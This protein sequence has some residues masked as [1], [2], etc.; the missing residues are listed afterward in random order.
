MAVSTQRESPFAGAALP[1][2]DQPFRIEQHGV[3]FIPLSERWARPRDVASMWAGASVQIEYF[4]YGAVLMTFG[5]TFAQALSLIIIGNLSYFLLGLCSLQGPQTGTTVF[6]INRASYGPNGSRVI[7][8]FNWLTQ[9]GFEVEG[10]ILIVGAALVLQTKAGFTAGTPAKVIFVLLAVAVQAVLPFLGHAT[11]VR[12]LRFLAIP[13]LVLFAVLLAFALPHATTTGVA[14]AADWQTYME[15]LAFTIVLSGLGWAECGND[16]SRYCRPDTSAKAIVGWVFLA[17]AVPEILIMT[18]GAAVGTF[19]PSVGKA[20]NAF[21]P[22]AHQHFIPAWFVVVFLVFSIV[23]LFAINS[24]DVYSS[25][26]T[27]QAMGVHVKRYV[28]VL[29]DCVIALGVTLYAIFASSFATYLKDFVDVVI[30]WIAPWAA[31][32]LTD[33]AMRRFRYV[34][35]ELQRTGRAS[36][37]YRENGVFWPAIVA[38][39][40][41]MYAAIS[42]LAATFPLPR[43]LNELTYATRDSYGYGADFSVFLGP[44]VAAVVYLALGWRGVR[45]QAAAQ[46]AA[47]AESAA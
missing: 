31:I 46:D 42:A 44:A 25:G 40:V 13:F 24:L 32:F 45:R 39:I 8:F 16:Y 10:L 19:L 30:V 41:G 7:A 43:W 38:Q 26:V 3:D 21:L 37:Y 17:T 36:L 5:F 2:G 11:I 1:E 20:S 34:P 33:W 12:T 18:L 23:Q 14:H 28:A 4:I 27:L 29:I 22:F 9:I 6:G 35:R 47:L 15:G